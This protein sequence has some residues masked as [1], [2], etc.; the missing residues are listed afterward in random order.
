M[1]IRMHYSNA[2]NSNIYS[3]FEGLLIVWQFERWKLFSYKRLFY[4]LLVIIA[5]CWYA[6]VFI[7]SSI[8]RFSS[9]FIITSSFITVMLSISMM[10][11]ILID[12]EPPLQLN[13]V[14]LICICFIALYTYNALLEIFWI[15]GLGSSSSFRLYIYRIFYFINLLTNLTYALALLWIPKKREFIVLS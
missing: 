2:V 9:Y 7:I 3:L 10:N 15:Y 5:A 11:K 13:P 8:H 14:F 1:T 6:E 4:L 12:Q